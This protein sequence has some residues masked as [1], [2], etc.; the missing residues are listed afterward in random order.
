MLRYNIWSPKF[1]PLSGGIRV[2]YGLRSWLETKGQTVDINGPINGNFIAIYPE[3]LRVNP[4]KATNIVRYVLQ[5]PGLMT[6]F[7]QPGPTSFPDEKVFVFSRLYDT[8]GVDEDHI[9]FLPILNLHLFKDQKKQ[10]KG[11]CVYVRRPSG[12]PVV[13]GFLVNNIINDQVALADYLNT[14]EVMYGYGPATAM[15]D[16]ARLCGCRV[17]IMPTEDKF[18]QTREEFAKYEL[19]QDFNGISWGADEGK[20]LDSDSFREC[21]INLRK[22]FD[23]KI[24]TFIELTQ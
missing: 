3:I 5:K 24:D 15:Y 13:D 11:K 7:G 1:D 4:F 16:I 17:V 19:C 8:I 14:V 18:K 9:M 23:K 12:E 21:Y 22:L 10:R 6:T 20:K 2:L